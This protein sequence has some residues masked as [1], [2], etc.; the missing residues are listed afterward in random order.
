MTK[1][2]NSF[3]FPEDFIP[4]LDPPHPVPVTGPAFIR[5]I[6]LFAASKSPETEK[7]ISFVW[8]Y[9]TTM[10]LEFTVFW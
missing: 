8:L 1:Q 6:L 3:A 5:K 9:D 4:N 7:V 10:Y 2:K